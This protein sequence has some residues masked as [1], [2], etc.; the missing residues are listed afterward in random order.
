MSF[1]PNFFWANLA[2]PMTSVLLANWGAIAAKV[3]RNCDT[4]PKP[5]SQKYIGVKYFKFNVNFSKR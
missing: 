3:A 2:A 5:E 1:G 4:A